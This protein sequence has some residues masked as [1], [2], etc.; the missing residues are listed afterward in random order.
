MLAELDSASG[1][2]DKNKPAIRVNGITCANVRV[3]TS[4][5]AAITAKSPAPMTML[6]GMPSSR[7]PSQT[8]RGEPSCSIW[9]RRIV[10]GG[11]NVIQEV[12][13]GLDAAAKNMAKEL[14]DRASSFY[15]RQ[16]LALSWASR[17][18]G[19]ADFNTPKSD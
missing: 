14:A 6:S 19:V 16:W 4:G 13:A 7:I 1:K 15:T 3:S 18:N 8:A 10:S 12:R 5:C 9:A 17:R 11:M 2:F